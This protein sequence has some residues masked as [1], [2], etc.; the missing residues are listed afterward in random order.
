MGRYRR[1]RRRS[2]GERV[3]L[4]LTGCE[5]TS[6]RR[7][8]GCRLWGPTAAASF[9]RRRATAGWRGLE[10]G[11]DGGC[12]V[13]TDV[14][15]ETP[16]A[17]RRCATSAGRAGPGLVRGVIVELGQRQV[18]RVGD[19]SLRL[20]DRG[21]AGGGAGRRRPRRTCAATSGVTAVAAAPSP[22][23]AHPTPAP[24]PSGARG[25]AAPGRC[26]PTVWCAPVRPCSEPRL[27][28]HRAV[29]QPELAVVP[30]AD[31]G[32]AGR[33]GWLAAQSLTSALAAGSTGL[34]AVCGE[35]VES[36]ESSQ[37]PALGL[38]HM[39]DSTHICTM[40]QP[41]QAR[42]LWFLCVS[43]LTQF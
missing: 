21:A 42:F 14:A 35:L 31:E 25:P 39:Y 6:S 12:F 3:N 10:G 7:A 16:T 1:R 18:A 37:H 22:R 19:M 13:G 40:S 26:R 28:R 36:C 23:T 27:R 24:P 32:D 30:F 43:Y 41:F 5:P 38:K 29:V 8:G 34:E 15:L 4:A 11:G 17:R 33:P 20:V 2:L 9:R